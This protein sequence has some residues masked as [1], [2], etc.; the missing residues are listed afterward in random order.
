MP[1]LSDVA[2][3]DEPSIGLTN[4]F[5]AVHEVWSRV[6]LDNREFDQILRGYSKGVGGIR[7][8]GNRPYSRTRVVHSTGHR[9]IGAIVA[10]DKGGGID[11]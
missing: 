1:F 7:T 3:P 11:G 5:S 4:K 6:S 8:G 10:H 9:G 2:G